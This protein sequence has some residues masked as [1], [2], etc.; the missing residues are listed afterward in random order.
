MKTIFVSSTFQDMHYERDIIH[1]RVTPALNAVARQYGESVAFCDL[2]WGVNTGELESEA[3]SRKVLSV[4]LE[5][6]DRCRPY[7]LVIWGIAMAG[8]PTRG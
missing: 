4:C 1:D 7:M 6:I 5:E 2:R 8:F 3:G